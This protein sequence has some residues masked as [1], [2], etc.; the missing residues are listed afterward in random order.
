MM[1]TYWYNSTFERSWLLQVS[2]S[3]ILSQCGL[4]SLIGHQDLHLR[5]T[6]IERQVKDEPKSAKLYLTRGELYGQHG[7]FTASLADFNRAE[8]LDATLLNVRL[9][10]AE[11]YLKMGEHT[12]AVTEANAFLE[13]CSGN[14]RGHLVRARAQRALREIDLADQDYEAAARLSLTPQPDLY[15]EWH[16]MFMETKPP[17]QLKRALSV[18]ELGMKRLGPLNTFQ[19]AAINCERLRGTTNAALV[20]VGVLEAEGGNRIACF[21]LRGDILAEAERPVEAKLAYTKALHAFEQMPPRR[22][23]LRAWQRMR[24]EINARLAQISK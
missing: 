19:L 17:G 24:T 10:R 11:L 16:T 22:Q 18:L 1:I 7:D 13:A 4:V 3:F 5:I 8:S 2:L 14:V 9:S 6:E 20:R 21:Q 12:K 15:L 23:R